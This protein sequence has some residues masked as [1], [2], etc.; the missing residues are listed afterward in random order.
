MLLANDTIINIVQGQSWGEGEF[1]LMNKLWDP[2]SKYLDN[3]DKLLIRVDLALFAQLEHHAM[4]MTSPNMSKNM[5]V[6]PSS[7]DRLQTK[8][9][10]KQKTCPILEKLYQTKEFSDVMINCG[11]K[12]FA[13]HKCIISGKNDI[14]LLKFATSLAIFLIANFSRKSRH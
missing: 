7:F 14:K 11:D 13:V 3:Q 4:D 1:I 10:G 2:I 12:T 6:P 8:T 9:L 5:M